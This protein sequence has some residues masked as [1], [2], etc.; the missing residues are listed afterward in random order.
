MRSPQSV[1]DVSERV[2]RVTPLGRFRELFCRPQADGPSRWLVTV[3][4]EVCC[5]LR[6]KRYRKPN[7]GKTWAGQDRGTAVGQFTPEHIPLRMALFSLVRGLLHRKARA[8]R[9][10][11]IR[12]RLRSRLY[13][14]MTLTLRVRGRVL[15]TAIRPRGTRAKAGRTRCASF[16][17][18]W[19]RRA[20]AH[21]INPAAP[22]KA[23]AHG[24]YG[25][26]PSPGR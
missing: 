23:G 1:P 3:G 4:C 15:T 17:F 14:I 19:R 26:R 12:R 22:A 25:S 7:R 10:H 16:Q 18:T 13:R 5:T 2:S 9:T 6:C 8:H 21:M 24:T 11:R 20:D